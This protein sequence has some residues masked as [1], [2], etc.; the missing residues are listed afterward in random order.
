MPRREP[1]LFVCHICEMY[2]EIMEKQA[3]SY[4]KRWRSSPILGPRLPGLW[5]ATDVPMGGRIHH[6]HETH[7]K[8]KA[9]RGLPNLLGGLCAWWYC[10]YIDPIRAVV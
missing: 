5:F 4:T 8:R 9:K 3:Y 6:V 1:Y 2:I 7:L 10:Q